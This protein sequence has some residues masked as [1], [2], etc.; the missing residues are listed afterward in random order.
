MLHSAQI[1]A[2]AIDSVPEA[3]QLD[4]PCGV[5]RLP[6]FEDGHVSVQ[7]SGAQCTVG[8]M[9]LTSSTS[10]A[11]LRVLDACAAPGGKAMHMLE[12][13][14]NIVLVALDIASDRL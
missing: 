6:G 13:E 10:E 14:P 8:F 3:I 1:N 12:L 4:E 7:D 9:D 5:E 11:P 2:A